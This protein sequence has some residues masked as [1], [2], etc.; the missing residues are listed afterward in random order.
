[1][2]LGRT[3]LAVRRREQQDMAQRTRMLMMEKVE[4]DNK[5]G[6]EEIVIDE[7]AFDCFGII[8]K[9]KVSKARGMDWRLSWY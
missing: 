3:S 5:M 6:R 8:C 9:N 2:P 7:E 4:D 1:M